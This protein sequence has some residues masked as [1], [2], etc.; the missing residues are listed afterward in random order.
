M[1]QRDDAELR[2]DALEGMGEEE[3]L[4]HVAAVE[5]VAQHLH[6]RIV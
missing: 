2:R 4:L 1:I 5:C 3:G 6:V